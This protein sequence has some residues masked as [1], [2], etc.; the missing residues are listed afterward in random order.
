MYRLDS[1]IGCK[2]AWRKTSNPAAGVFWDG[3]R[4]RRGHSSGGR[5]RTQEVS[6][7][8]KSGLRSELA[9]PGT[10]VPPNMMVVVSDDGKLFTP[11]PD[12]RSF[13]IKRIFGPS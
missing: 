10:G 5:V 3:G 6:S 2:G 13:T 9:Q 12:A 11:F 4:R 8:S 7:I 1:A